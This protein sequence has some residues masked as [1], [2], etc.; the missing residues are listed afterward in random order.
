MNEMNIRNI[1]MISTILLITSSM[2]GC[3]GCRDDTI[4][5]TEIDSWYDV[6]SI[7]L[8]YTGWSW[9][10]IHYITDS[11]ELVMMELCVDRYPLDG[12]A[13]SIQ[14]YP[15]TNKGVV[16]HTDGDAKLRIVRRIDVQGNQYRQ[17]HYFEI[18]LYI[19]D[20]TSIDVGDDRYTRGRSTHTA[21]GRTIYTKASE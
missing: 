18:E 5:V 21:T 17:H 12:P 7:Q 13:K 15:S 10:S 11:D 19:P 16:Y 3:I 4:T 20:K 2:I 6:H 1:V 8:H 14:P 9:Y